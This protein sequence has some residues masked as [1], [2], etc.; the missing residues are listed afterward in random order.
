MLHPHLCPGQFSSASYVTVTVFR[1]LDAISA[2]D[3]DSYLFKSQSIL[4]YF[5][6]LITPSSVDDQ[7]QRDFCIIGELKCK[8]L[9]TRS[10]SRPHVARNNL[11]L[12]EQQP[13]FV[14]EGIVNVFFTL[15][16]FPIRLMNKANSVRCS[17]VDRRTALL[18]GLG[19]V[20]KRLD[21]IH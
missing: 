14:Y 17:W 3:G 21:Q 16:V 1:C 6:Y 9:S 12:M 13:A 10:R 19:K 18:D 5:S 8:T 20:L 4:F 11:Y 7:H 2:H 15:R